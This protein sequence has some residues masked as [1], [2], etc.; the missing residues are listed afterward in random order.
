MNRSPNPKSCP[1][2][3]GRKGRLLKITQP[4]PESTR[5]ERLHA[6]TPHFFLFF[7]TSWNL[8]RAEHNHGERLE[9]KL[10]VLD[11]ET[12][13]QPGFELPSVNQMD[14]LFEIVRGPGRKEESFQ[15]SVSLPQMPRR[16]VCQ[17]RKRKSITK[18]KQSFLEQTLID[19]IALPG[20]AD[21]AILH[22]NGVA[23]AAVTGPRLQIKMCTR[24]GP[25]SGNVADRERNIGLANFGG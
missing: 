11:E 13:S 10:R 7:V 23:L 19:S 24:R 4:A 25:V 6:F 9:L 21:D 3:F 8:C 22:R 16:E 1:D 12:K 15:P 17:R 20:A 2:K 18:M 5:S 14:D